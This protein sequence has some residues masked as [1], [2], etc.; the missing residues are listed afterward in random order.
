M[1]IAVTEKAQLSVNAASRR[2][3]LGAHS[4][5]IYRI[6]CTLP[7]FFDARYLFD[8]NV[9]RS[10]PR[11]CANDG[12]KNRKGWKRAAEY[13]KKC[14]HGAC[15][16]V[17]LAEKMGGGEIE[18]FPLFHK[19]CKLWYREGDAPI[20]RDEFADGGWNIH[21]ERRRRIGLR[22][23]ATET[24]KRERRLIIELPRISG[25]ISRGSCLLISR[26]DSAWN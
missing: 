15:T 22:V 8:V 6:A 20:A 18:K 9:A 19:N 12:K 25:M 1:R 5:S 26:L 2:A 11:I 13:R 21:P 16:A 23:V 17:F 10:L 4:R 7:L 3:F 14:S 24:G